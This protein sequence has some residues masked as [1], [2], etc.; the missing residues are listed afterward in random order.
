MRQLSSISTA[1]AKLLLFASV[2]IT[3]TLVFA[4]DADRPWLPIE[5]WRQSQGL[6]QNSV[7]A[8]LQ[9]HDGYIWIGTKGGLARFDGVHFKVYDDRDQTQLRESEI[10]SL[11]EGDDGSLWIATYGGG[12]SRLKDGKF[13]IYTKKDGLIG[14]AAAE[15]CKDSQGNIWIATDQGLSVFK[16]NKFTSYT[17]K[18]GL[19]SNAV[20]ALYADDDDT[21]WIGTTKGGVHHLKDGKI[22]TVK[23]AGMESRT[24]VEEFTRD[25]NGDLWLATNKGVYRLHDD[26]QDFFTTAQGLSS[27]NAVEVYEDHDGNVW[28]GDQAGLDRF[29]RATNTFTKAFAGNWINAI[30]S[31]REGNLWIGDSNDGL[32]RLR[33]TLFTTYTEEDGL[34]NDNTNVVFQDSHHKVWVGTSKG[35]SYLHGDKFKQL[36][37]AE[38]NDGTITALGEDRDGTVLVAVG[39]RLYQLQYPST[40]KDESCEPRVKQL[41]TP[42]LDGTSV[43]VIFAD[44]DGAVWIGTAFDGLLVYKD[45]SFTS[46]ST[47]NGLSSNAVRGIVQDQDG[48]IWIGT[49]GGGLNHFK[50]GSFT[51]YTTKDGLANDGVQALYLDKTNTLWIGTREGVNRF[52]DGKFVTYRITDGLFGSFVYNFIEDDYGNL[53]MGCSKGIFRVERKELDEFA[54]GKRSSIN[55]IAYGLEH[56]LA[57]TVGVVAQN[58]SSYKTIDG[59]LWFCLLKGVSVIDPRH[60]S[61]NA[62]PPLVDIDAAEIDG[63]N[64]GPGAMAQAKP[65]RGNL[66]F[67]YTGLSF[68]AAEKVR[69]KYKLEGYDEQWIDA[70]NRREAFYSNIPPGNYVFR[71]IAMNSDG[72]WNEEGAS[73]KLKLAAH[74]YQTYWFYAS[75]AIVACLLAFFFYA[76]RAQQMKLRARELAELVAVRTSE[77]QTQSI[78]LQRAKEAAEA[79][80]MAK[81]NFLANMSHEIRTPMNGVIGMTGLLLDTDL[82]PA[83][84]DYT[85]TI[86][87][88]AEALMTV[89]NDILDFSKIEAGK[90][91]FEKIDFDLLPVVES[92]VELL[93]GKAQ[94]KGLEMASLVESDVPMDLQG[95][96]N[97]L[98]QVLTNLLGNAVKFTERGEI[99]LRVTTEMV[100]ES[101]AFIKFSITDTGIGISDEEQEK[102]FQAF[103]QADGSTTRKYGGTGLGLAISKQLAELMGGE[104]GVSSNHGSGSTFWFTGLF[105][106]QQGSR[107]SEVDTAI[108]LEGLRV[109]IVDDSSTNR[110]ILEHH[111]KS[112]GLE[113]RSADSGKAA[114]REIA[115]SPSPFDI[116]VID[117]QMPDM[118]GL[119]LAREI[120]N[121]YDKA[122]PQILMLTS[123]GQHCDEESRANGIAACL[124]KPV[125]KLQL[126]DALQKLV[127]EK[128][129]PKMNGARKQ[130][131]AHRAHEASPQAKPRILV[132]E[133]NL[134]NQ[135]VALSQLR[136]LGYSA[137]A[138]GN[139]REAMM[140]LEAFPYPAVLMDCQMPEMDGYEATRRI[141]ER[142]DGTL[143]HTPIIALTAHAMEGE[144]RK[145]IDAG[146]DDYLSKPVKIDELASVLSRWAAREAVL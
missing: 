8:I 36:E 35:L 96:P 120:T 15:L 41:V 2:L 107:T 128:I 4:A 44:R 136:K 117:M 108:K 88:S 101:H 52:K 65:G 45:G 23:I 57:S 30:Y 73:F 66:V 19:T 122:S 42:L 87:S 1:L 67:H 9:T 91:S 78:D 12:V 11:A 110:Q 98:R 60:L 59:R 116:A 63:Q 70:G 97:R 24:V 71:V 62:V 126:I 92:S 90:L 86:N 61:S 105:E 58:P 18:D 82:S 144:R 68:F 95:D 34:A 140:A 83:Q 32:A 55:S 29:N 39:D 94:L 84:K 46:Y 135:R 77:L 56:G 79:A 53:W 112:K 25:Q 124:T 13:T 5:V 33:Q 114:L 22:T 74:V 125:R 37:L 131:Y 139:G 14:D 49:K 138:V 40:C 50:D 109:L 48:S 72:V 99:V 102:L 100:T 20:R 146:M 134:V 111:L 38:G 121:R 76:M 64:F 143:H 17:V 113:I 85:E 115:E 123:L 129:G 54:E 133:D 69:F 106:R 141:R 51:S 103:S 142:E 81:S 6:P 93:S 7:K 26:K 43:K 31:D 28:I 132:A 118:D 89:I 3:P 21:I 104:I 119:M 47:R 145:C 80:T 127:S 10:W 16:D 75:C 137:D 27:N 130:M